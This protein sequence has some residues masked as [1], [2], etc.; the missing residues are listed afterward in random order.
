MKIT[1]FFF[2]VVSV[3]LVIVTLY[4][5]LINKELLSDSYYRLVIS[6]G[7]FII[8]LIILFI[9]KSKKRQQHSK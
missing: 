9:E 3:G 5:V 1:K 6:F 4:R 8:W 2:L 7:C